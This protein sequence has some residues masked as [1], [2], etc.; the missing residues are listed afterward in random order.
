MQHRSYLLEVSAGSFRPSARAE[1]SLERATPGTWQRARAAWLSVGHGFW[2]ARSRWTEARWRQHLNDAAVSFRLA[3]R[4]GQDVGF[5]ELVVQRRGVKIE[6]FGLL[7]SARGQGLGG[8]LLSAA[9]SEAFGLGA[10]RVWL[11]TATDDHP[12]AL[13]NYLARGFKVYRERALR[14]P[15]PPR[16]EA[17]DEAGRKR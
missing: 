3:R 16:A 8:P 13:P 12:C 9:T 1:L 11:H 14:N 2:T 5:F 6:G 15:M 7:P 4:H 17:D 10:S